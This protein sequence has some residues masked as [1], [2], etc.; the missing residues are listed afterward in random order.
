MSA[1]QLTLLSKLAAAWDNVPTAR[2][3]QLLESVENVAWDICPQR[4]CAPR[5]LWLGDD[6]FETALDRWNAVPMVRKVVAA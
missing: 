5:L 2:L 4:V 6:L 3:G 1:H